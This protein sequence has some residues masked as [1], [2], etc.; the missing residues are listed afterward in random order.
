[1]PV[2]ESLAL[3]STIRQSTLTFIDRL[4]ADER[5]NAYTQHSERGKEALDRIL[6]MT[7]GHDVN[8]LETMAKLAGSR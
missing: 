7:A 6:E 5:A 4:S 2:D 8:H 3:F 1:M